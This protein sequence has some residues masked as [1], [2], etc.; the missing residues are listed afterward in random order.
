MCN[1]ISSS[2]RYEAKVVKRA[3]QD[4]TD[5]T[6]SIATEEVEIG[7]RTNYLSNYLS[8]RRVYLHRLDLVTVSSAFQFVPSPYKITHDDVGC[9]RIGRH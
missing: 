3:K 5:A 1:K 9:Y 2:H 6:I 7:E 4:A 8:E